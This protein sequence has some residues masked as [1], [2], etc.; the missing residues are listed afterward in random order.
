MSITEIKSLLQGIIGLNA[1]TVGASNFE[2]AVRHRMKICEINEVKEY[3]R[4]LENSEYEVKELIEEVVIPETWFFRNQQSFIAF[5]S[6]IKDEWL[7]NNREKKLKIL[8]APSST[9][10]EPYSIVMSLDKHGLA[11][12]YFQ[13]DAIDI[14]TR[15]LSKAKRG[16]YGKH[17]FR[18]KENNFIDEIGR[19]SCRER[20]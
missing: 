14:S 13:L 12:D 15:L 2:R 1:N 7:V 20:V 4:E 6:Y 5:D 8:S 17:S 10:E 18:N 3:L 19:A 9:G 11:G 16:V